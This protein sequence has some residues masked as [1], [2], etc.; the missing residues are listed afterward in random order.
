MPNG[1]INDILDLFYQLYLND[2]FANHSFAFSDAHLHGRVRHSAWV[3]Y[4]YEPAA[5]S[6]PEPGLLALVGLGCSA[7][8]L[9]RAVRRAN[10]P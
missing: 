6:V 5:A 8:G 9:R 4:T 7:F 2:V 3:T 10:R 1:S